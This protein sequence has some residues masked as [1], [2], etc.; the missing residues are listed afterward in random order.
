MA[1]PS[2]KPELHRY[3][4]GIPKSL[5]TRITDRAALMNC[6]SLDLILR[7]IRV[8]LFVHDKLDT[9]GSKL[10]VHTDDGEIEIFIP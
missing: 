4:M 10:I 6:S 3:N 5:W 8:G 1:K 2:E 7:Y 9:P